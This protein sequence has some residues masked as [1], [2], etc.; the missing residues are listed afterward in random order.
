MNNLERTGAMAGGNERCD[1]ERMPL[2]QT[3]PEETRHRLKYICTI[4]DVSAGA[5][6]AHQGDDVRSVYFVRRGLLRMQKQLVDGRIQIVGL[7]A[8]GHMAGTVFVEKHAFAIE[9]ASRSEVIA[10]HAKQFRLAV[11]CDRDLERILFRGFQ[12]EVDA[13]LNWLLLLS[14]SK[15]RGRLAGFLL[16][17]LA[18]YNH[19][20]NMVDERNETISLAIPISRIDLANLIGV[21]PESLSRAFHALADDGR[22]EIV[23]HDHVILCDIE[24]LSEEVG[25]SDLIDTVHGKFKGQKASKSW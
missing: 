8:P 13:S 16:I 18:R 14:N 5:T 15:V 7:L 4:H 1:L 19:L 2:F 20:P 21:R 3:L 25:D 6:L 24:G 22:I 11:G 9:A 12:D 23:K 10:F 17:L